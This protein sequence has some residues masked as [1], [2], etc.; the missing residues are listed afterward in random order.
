MPD[1]QHEA[2]AFLTRLWGGPKMPADLFFSL[3]YRSASGK[4]AGSFSA[5]HWKGVEASVITNRRHDGY[6]NACATEKKP[7]KGRATAATAAAIP[8]LWLD[9]DVN[10]GPENRTGYAPTREA[11]ITLSERIFRPSVLIDSGYGVQAWWLFPEPWIFQDDD[12]RDAAADL[13]E[14]WVESHRRLTDWK[15]DSVGDLARLMRLPGTLNHKGSEQAPVSTIRLTGEAIPRDRLATK[16][17]AR[18]AGARSTPRAAAVAAAATELADLPGPADVNHQA[19]MAAFEA[20]IEFARTYKREK[21]AKTSRWSD[22]EFDLAIISTL[23]GS[24]MALRPAVASTMESRRKYGDAEKGDKITR[25][26]YWQRT[27]AK[28]LNGRDVAADKE[29]Q[30]ELAVELSHVAAEPAAVGPSQPEDV[31]KRW[32]IFNKALGLTGQQRA[33][34]WRQYGTDPDTARQVL[35]LASGLEVPLG[36]AMSLMNQAKTRSAMLVVGR[37]P[38]RNTKQGIWLDAWNAVL[39][40]RLDE[41]ESEQVRD[42]LALHWVAGAIERGG[43]EID[44]EHFAG[45]LAERRPVLKDGRIHVATSHL[46]QYLRSQRIRPDVRDTDLP[47]LLTAAGFEVGKLSYQKA[48]GKRSSASYWSIA[49]DDLP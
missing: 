24:G 30:E 6:L 26:D 49:Q 3:W 42:Q 38:I 12:D 2:V 8:G 7:P 25:L 23:T 47:P 27:V 21:W 14:R 28:A 34:A 46:G 48:D 19:L 17:A 16:A 5:Q 4:P 36:T 40:L 9:L 37:I 10:G 1:E 13:A 22:S 11:A 20:S 31:T 41:E 29:A 15:L 39:P 18:T 44:T 43:V 32:A 35:I 45:A 33:V